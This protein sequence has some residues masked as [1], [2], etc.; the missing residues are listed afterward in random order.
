MPSRKKSDSVRTISPRVFRRALAKLTPPSDFRDPQISSTL[1][2]IERVI[3]REGGSPSRIKA[4]LDKLTAQPAPMY[5]RGGSFGSTFRFS[6][7]SVLASIWS[8]L[9]SAHRY[10]RPACAA[11]QA[12]CW[13]SSR[14]HRKRQRRDRQNL[15]YRNCGCYQTCRVRLGTRFLFDLHQ[16][17]LL[18][19]DQP[20]H[21]RS[22]RGLV[23]PWSIEYRMALW[24]RRCRLG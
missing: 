5:T 2:A 12:L 3:S 6:P 16:P 20:C 8:G 9:Y 19:K 23:C 1:K 11:V 10:R 7:I 18:R 14:W 22:R 24:S 15:M 17:S 21:T 4:L 13:I